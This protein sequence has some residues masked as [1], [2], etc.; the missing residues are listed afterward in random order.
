MQEPNAA[1]GG[2]AGLL[3]GLLI[4]ERLTAENRDSDSSNYDRR[5]EEAPTLL[6]TCKPQEDAGESPPS[7][8]RIPKMYLPD[9]QWISTLMI[10]SNETIV[11]NTTC[12]TRGSQ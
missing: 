5:N 2:T 6:E 7:K 8:T 1:L 4:G 10:L 9:F 12:V 3:G 11:A